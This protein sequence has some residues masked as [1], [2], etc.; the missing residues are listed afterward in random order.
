M[1]DMKPGYLT[2]EFWASAIGALVMI[3]VGFGVIP[4]PFAARVESGL[5]DAVEAIVSVIGSVG[6]IMNYSLGRTR[7]KLGRS[8]TRKRTS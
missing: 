8:A 2:T 3:L 6:L 7:V 5:V 1:N 4:A